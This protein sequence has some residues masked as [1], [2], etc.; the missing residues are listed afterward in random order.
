MV[1][2]KEIKDRTIFLY[3]KKNS[4]LSD[5]IK[6]YDYTKVNKVLARNS[7]KNFKTISDINVRKYIVNWW[8]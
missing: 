1:K 2:P 4:E 7:S 6:D 8:H 3:N 5:Y